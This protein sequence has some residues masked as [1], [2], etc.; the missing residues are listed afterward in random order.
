MGMQLI[1]L[2][3]QRGLPS[4]LAS[5]SSSMRGW[6]SSLNLVI[7]RIRGGGGGRQKR[8]EQGGEKYGVKV[9]GLQGAGKMKERE[10]V[11]WERRRGRVEE[12]RKD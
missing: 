12:G 2:R 11:I 7:S 4:P 5:S 6:K 1:L 8:C 10:K 9:K 3:G